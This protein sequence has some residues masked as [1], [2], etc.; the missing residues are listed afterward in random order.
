MSFSSALDAELQYY[1]LFNLLIITNPSL[2][3]WAA[4]TLSDE[5]NKI[6]TFSINSLEINILQG[7]VGVQTIAQIPAF[8]RDL[9]YPNNFVQYR[10]NQNLTDTM[11]FNQF[12][13]SSDATISTNSTFNQQ[14]R[15]S[16]RIII[17]AFDGA[18]AWSLTS[19]AT[20]N[21]QNFQLDI[22]IVGGNQNSPSL[23][24]TFVAIPEY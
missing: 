3:G 9:T 1:Y 7:Q 2:I 20:N 10:I 22:F 11:A 5:N 23:L 12:F 16:Y 18:P 24:I 6:P 21:V 15:S 13:I 14:N 4:I 19:N 17:T 8:D